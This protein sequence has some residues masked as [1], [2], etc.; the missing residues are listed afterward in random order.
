MAEILLNGGELICKTSKAFK[1]FCKKRRKKIGKQL[2]YYSK[3]AIS[4]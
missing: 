3:T 4:F 1:L 2:E